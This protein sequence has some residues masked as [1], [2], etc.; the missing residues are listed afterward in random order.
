MHP[1]GSQ[2]KKS[3]DDYQL[4]RDFSTNL[5]KNRIKNRKRE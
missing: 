5:L 4:V 3:G 1:R 2:E